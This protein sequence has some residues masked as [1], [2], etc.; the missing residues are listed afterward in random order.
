M[1]TASS[2]G[3]RDKL[4]MVMNQAARDPGGTSARGGSSGLVLDV[5]GAEVG[6]VFSPH[7]QPHLPI[8]GARVTP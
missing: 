3:H 7:T 2:Q 1:G 8:A 4:S 5:L 6:T